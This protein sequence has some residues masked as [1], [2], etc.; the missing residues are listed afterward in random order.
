[1]SCVTVIHSVEPRSV[2]ARSATLSN[3]T[4]VRAVVS[5]IGIKFLYLSSI[6]GLDERTLAGNCTAYNKCVDFVGAFVGIHCFGVSMEASNIRVEGDA[7][8]TTCFTSQ[9]D[10]FAKF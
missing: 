7:V 5:V 3:S 4:T 6:N 9:R 10:C 2:P 8:A 1:M